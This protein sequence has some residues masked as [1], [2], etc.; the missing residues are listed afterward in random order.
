MIRHIVMWRMNAEDAPGRAAQAQKVSETLRA[1]K[2]V[3]PEIIDI[4]VEPN[5]AYE[6]QN[7]DV[8]LVAD[9][10]DLDALAR[11]IVHPSH[12]EA[13]TFVRSVAAERAAVDFTF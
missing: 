5:V 6:G 1:L 3:V 12:E 2:G 13:A 10:A 11:Y 9:F 7:W 4:T 8:V